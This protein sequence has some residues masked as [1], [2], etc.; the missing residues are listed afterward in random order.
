[1]DTRTNILLSVITL[2]I[3]YLIYKNYTSQ[4]LPIMTTPTSNPTFAPTTT[5]YTTTTPAKI[6]SAPTTTPYPTTTTPY[7]T[8]TPAKITSAPTTTTP[9]PT[10]T[11]PY[12][13]T[14]PAKITSAPTTT[15]YPTTYSPVIKLIDG[16]MTKDTYKE[17]TIYNYDDIPTGYNAIEIYFHLDNYEFNTTPPPPNVIIYC[18]VRI[19]SDYCSYTF[20]LSTGR[21]SISKK[22]NNVLTTNEDPKQSIILSVGNS[23]TFSYYISYSGLNKITDMKTLSISYKINALLNLPTQTPTISP[24]ISPTI[25]PT[26]TPIITSPTPIITSPTPIITSPTPIPK[27][28]FTVSCVNPNSLDITWYNS[29]ILQKLYT[30]NTITINFNLCELTKVDKTKTCNLIINLSSNNDAGTDVAYILTLEY[31]LDLNNNL[32]LAIKY[33][34]TFANK[35]GVIYSYVRKS[36][37]EKSYKVKASGKQPDPATYNDVYGSNVKNFKYTCVIT[38][39]DTIPTPASTTAPATPASTTAPATHSTYI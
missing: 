9:Y 3:V 34:G 16:T 19:G 26:T 20:Y 27:P 31:T 38:E 24:T 5:P 7:P 8:T 28:D 29:S 37:S 33:N 14:T 12:P 17:N 25:I 21:M 22:I 30:K 18:T 2:F 4:H 15:P 32:Q 36:A 23:K 6:T 39:S 10:T 1:M 11:T 35:T 13:T